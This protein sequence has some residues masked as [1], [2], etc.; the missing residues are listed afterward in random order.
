MDQK[1]CEKWRKTKIDPLTGYVLKKSSRRNIE[2]KEQC[3]QFPLTDAECIQL[4]KDKINPRTQRRLVP[5][6]KT[7]R[8]L[9]N[10]CSGGDATTAT[11]TKN[12]CKCWLK[13]K[14][15][16][17]KTNRKI[18]Q[19]GKI[20]QTYKNICLPEG[21]RERIIINEKCIN[22]TDPILLEDFEDAELEDDIIIIGPHC[23][24]I[25]SLFHHYKTKFQNRE[26]ITNPLNLA[27][28][29]TTQQISELKSKMKKK[30]PNLKMP[31]VTKFK[32]PSYMKLSFVEQQDF[33]KIL[34]KVRNETFILGYVPSYIDQNFSGSND[35][36]SAVLIYKLKQL[37]DAGRLMYTM[38]PPV[39]CSIHLHQR[40]Y[41]NDNILTKFNSLMAEIDQLLD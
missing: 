25:E 41:W 23:Y 32:V 13:N 7:Y 9:I 26:P 36:T 10:E 38:Y 34:L 40:N 14:F 35:I 2:I 20:Y 16:N 12:D 39:C 31:K 3:D 29:L 37:W 8:S 22:E 21:K 30:Y 5:N 18:T 6:S 24:K 1:D 19:K 27:S 28:R 11:I 17:P 15:I 4:K 33:Y